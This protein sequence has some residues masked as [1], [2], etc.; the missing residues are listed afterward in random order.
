[1]YLSRSLR[2]KDRI[3]EMVGIIPADAVMH[4]RPQGRGYVRLQETAGQPWPDGNDP[5]GFSAHE[6][7]YSSL[8]NISAPLDFAYRVMRGTGIDGTHDG[9]VIHNVLASYT[10]MRD[11]RQHRWAR[12]FVDFVRQQTRRDS[13]PVSAL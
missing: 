8:E 12:R 5:E 13:T 10:H 6:F 1:M 7:H 9:I 4:E 11:T 3:C 2:W